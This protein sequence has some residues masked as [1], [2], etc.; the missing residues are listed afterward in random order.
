MASTLLTIQEVSGRTRL[1]VPTLRYFRTRNEGPPS[2]RLGRRVLYR[3]SDVEAWID[4]QMQADAD[5]RR[6]VA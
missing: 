4:A 3:E 5:R 1:P 2:F 6:R